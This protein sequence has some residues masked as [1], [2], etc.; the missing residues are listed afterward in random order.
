[1]IK[2]KISILK[3]TRLEKEYVERCCSELGSLDSEKLIQLVFDAANSEPLEAHAKALGALGNRMLSGSM[4]GQVA[5]AL[6]AMNLVA[7]AEE[8]WLREPARE[9]LKRYYSREFNNKLKQ[10]ESK[11][12]VE[13]LEI[14]Q[15]LHTP[16]RAATLMDHIAKR[17]FIRGFTEEEKTRV[18]KV[19]VKLLGHP[20]N[21]VVF[22]A[23]FL[24]KELKM[25]WLS[26]RNK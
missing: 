4:N 3:K 16:E 10:V 24:L 5:E 6:I 25:P 7:S 13:L 9:T 8:E 22:E 26:A 20:D 17:A 14:G 2:E 18:A 15:G 12:L 11:T 21:I 19:A 1:M 23:A